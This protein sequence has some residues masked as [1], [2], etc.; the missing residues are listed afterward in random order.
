MKQGYSGSTVQRKGN[1]VEKFSN[2]RTLMDSQGR[3]NDLVAL[4]LKLAILPRIVHIDRQAIYMEYVD[5]QEGLTEHNARQAGKA[6]HLLHEQRD[7]PHP[8]M[9][10]LTWLIQMANLNLVRLDDSQIIMAE[11]EAEYPS[12][13]LIHSE[14][15]QFIEKQDGSIVFID[16]DGIGMG[17]HYQDL[18]FIYYTT[19]KEDKLEIYTTFL[20][21]YQ[22]ESG[23]AELARVKQLA[24]IISIA[25]AQFAEFEKRME[26]GLRLLGE[27]GQK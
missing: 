19:V 25:Y 21:G 24:G 10:G 7:Y 22:P 5:G 6:L 13:A 16:V 15:V 23:E 9:N 26:L 1:L 18:G 20:A 27:A 12:D 11:I 3:Q 17:T 4:S 14:P 8:C 2:D